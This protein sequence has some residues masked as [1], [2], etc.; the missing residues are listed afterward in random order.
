MYEVFHTQAVVVAQVVSLW[1]SVGAGRV[2]I[3]GWTWLFGLELLFI[4][5]N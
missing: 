1:Q 4:Y 3:P 2:R 5:S